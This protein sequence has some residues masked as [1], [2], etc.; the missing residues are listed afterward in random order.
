MGYIVSCV[1]CSRKSHYDY[2]QKRSDGWHC[3]SSRDCKIRAQAKN[4][5]LEA[6]FVDGPMDRKTVK[7]VDTT[8]DAFRTRTGAPLTL[9]E[10]GWIIGKM[11][12]S[13]G[14]NALY[15]LYF[16]SKKG[17]YEYG[18]KTSA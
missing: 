8:R 17:R 2:F 4:S 18:Y 12:Y 9:K 7:I 3:R 1:L 15:E 5:N 16:N 13:S 6:V 11:S 10:A 14:D